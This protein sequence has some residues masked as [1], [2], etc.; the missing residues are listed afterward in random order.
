MKHYPPMSSDYVWRLE[1]I[2]KDGRFHKRLNENGIGSVEEFCQ[3]YSKNQQALRTVSKPYLN[4]K[5]RYQR[6][7][8]ITLILL[9]WPFC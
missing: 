5:V 3:A 9:F 6:A 7:C 2:A 1:C 4:V 8:C